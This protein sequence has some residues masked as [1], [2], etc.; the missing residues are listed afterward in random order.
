MMTIGLYYDVIPGKGKEFEKKFYAVL[1]AMQNVDGHRASW[2]YQRVDDPDSYAI[3]AEWDQK[4]NFMAFIRSDAF[5]E[6]TAWGKE[7]ILRNR[8]RHKV[9]P[10]TQDMMGRP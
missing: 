3:I 8:P 1:E 4:E 5:R 6:V 9:Y 10:D 2:L 7:K